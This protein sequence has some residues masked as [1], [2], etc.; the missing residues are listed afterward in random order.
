M[1][2]RKLTCILTEDDVLDRGRQLA[3][4]EY[5][6]AAI[7]REKKAANDEFKKQL[8]ATSGKIVNLSRA[9]KNGEEERDVVCVVNDNW[10]NYKKE[11]VRTDTGE[12]IESY[13]MTE[14]ERQRSLIN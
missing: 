1:I 5:D 12:M 3:Q 14:A 8:D 6:L 10:G 11:V 13:D 2:T 4:T 9:I 7:E